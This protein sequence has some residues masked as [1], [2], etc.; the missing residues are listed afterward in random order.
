MRNILVRNALVLNV[1]GRNLQIQKS[2]G[3]T[4]CTKCQWRKVLSETPKSKRSGAGAKRPVSNVSGETSCLKRPSPKGPGQNVLIQNVRG[5]DLVQHVR[6]QKVRRRNILVKNVSGRNDLFQNGK[7]ESSWTKMSGS[8]TAWSETSG[9][10]S[11]WSKMSGA[12]CPGPKRQ[13][14]KSPGGGAKHPGPKCQWTKRPSL[15]CR[16]EKSWTKM[17]VAETS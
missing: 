16:G 14:T 5:P 11:T 13:G 3:E 4:S 17:S 12:E 7:G 15:K 2:R 10:L 6:V 9:S 1:R 8:E